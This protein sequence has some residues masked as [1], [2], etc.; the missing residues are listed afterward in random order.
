M[1]S[2]T[3][4]NVDL[5]NHANLVTRVLGYIVGQPCFTSI[6]IL[7]VDGRWAYLM[8]LKQL[9]LTTIMLLNGIGNV[10]LS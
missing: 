2:H 9:S 7:F 1:D 3:N 4:F 6:K 5:T 8:D 10:K